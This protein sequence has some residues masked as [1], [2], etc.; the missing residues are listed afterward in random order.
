MKDIMYNNSIIKNIN[1]VLNYGDYVEFEGII[2]SISL[3]SQ[4]NGLINILESYD[5]KILDKLLLEK[6]KAEPLTNFS[7]ILKQLKNLTDQLSR[8]STVNMLIKSNTSLY[9]VLNVN[10]NYFLDKNSYIYDNVN[11][12]C[13]VLCKVIKIVDQDGY[14]DLLDKT[15][16]SNYYNQW[17][18]QLK[19]YLNVLKKN[20]I[21][22][23]EEISN[24]LYFPAFQAIPIA[25][26]V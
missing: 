6:D 13:R 19:Y 20:N 24:K 17:L 2:S 12:N 4:L 5:T 1:N 9:T 14:I 8:N 3:Q 26:Y 18:Q 21:I 22:V 25:I 23:P 11:C 7:V 10:L 16:M 15:C